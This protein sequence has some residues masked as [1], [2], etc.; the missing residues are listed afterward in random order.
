MTTK[1]KTLTREEVLRKAIEKAVKGGWR[2]TYVFEFLE[3][4]ELLF[5]SI[6]YNTC[7]AT[8]YSKDFA[9]AFW[10]HLPIH[11]MSLERQRCDGTEID[12]YGYARLT[13]WQYH[14][15]Q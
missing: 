3:D 13:N 4:E 5:G 7:I 15:H 14:I 8:I 6:N 11:I 2:Q 9:K 10:S 12:D 1:P